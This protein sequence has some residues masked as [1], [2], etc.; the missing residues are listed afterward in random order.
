MNNSF[1]QP[2]VSVVIPVY[3]STQKHLEYLEQTIQSVANQTYKNFELIIIDDVSPLDINSTIEKIDGIETIRIIRNNI[4]LGHAESRNIGIRYAEG[5]L[6]AFLDHDDIW[7]PQ[8]LK[9]QVEILKSDTSIGF[10][11]CRCEIIGDNADRLNINQS[12]IPQNPD[13]CWFV[14]H[15]NFTITASAVLTH[16]KIME[17]IGLFDSRYSTC[18]DFDAWLK[19]CEKYKSAYMPEVL[20]KY[21]LHESNVNY[22]VDRLNDNILLTSLIWNYA[23]KTAFKEK[24]CLY[25]RI[26]RK[27]IGRIYFF[28]RRYREFK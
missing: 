8:K 7:L 25:P 5:E 21:R 14:K 18:D 26:V 23:K 10:V 3:S 28:F 20:I 16:K 4:N 22:T 1:N 2:L 15:G 11:F 27:L 6:I 9:K 12:I 24:L 19:I 17:E 13:F